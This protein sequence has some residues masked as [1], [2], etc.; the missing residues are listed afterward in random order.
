VQ[1]APFR[2]CPFPLMS[3]TEDGTLSSQHDEPAPHHLSFLSFFFLPVLLWCTK[4]SW[5]SLFVPSHLRLRRTLDLPSL[6]IFMHRLLDHAF[7]IPSPFPQKR[8]TDLPPR[9]FPPSSRHIEASSPSFL[10]FFFLAGRCA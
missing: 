6:S 10:V 2:L 7:V 9:S 5:L 3:H 4:S 1:H 8:G